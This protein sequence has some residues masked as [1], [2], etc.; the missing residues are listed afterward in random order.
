MHVFRLPLLKIVFAKSRGCQKSMPVRRWLAQNT[1]ICAPLRIDGKPCARAGG[2]GQVADKAREAASKVADAPKK[3]GG[4]FSFFN[5]GP[6]ASEVKGVAK[7]AASSAKNAL[8]DS[9]E[10]LSCESASHLPLRVG[11]WSSHFLCF[12]LGGCFPKWW[13]G[14]DLN[15]TGRPALC[16]H[17]CELGGRGGEGRGGPWRM[18]V[19]VANWHRKHKARRLG[20]HPSGHLH[21]L[22]NDVF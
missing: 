15:C 7:D 14:G 5:Q 22:P 10:P 16:M 4:F 8:P 13:K 2:A 12:L 3:G 18:C 1:T 6:K 20:G 9:G 19:N 17:V 11:V 21:S